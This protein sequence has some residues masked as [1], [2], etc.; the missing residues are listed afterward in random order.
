MVNR[1]FHTITASQNDNVSNTGGG[2]G[3]VGSMVIMY[4]F[5]EN[6]GSM[7]KT[8]KKLNLKTKIQIGQR[9]YSRTCFKPQLSSLGVWCWG[10]LLKVLDQKISRHAC[11]LI[12]FNCYYHFC[13]SVTWCMILVVKHY[14]RTLNTQHRTPKLESWVLKQVLEYPL[15]TPPLS[16]SFCGHWTCPHKFCI[17]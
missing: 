2:G 14:Y 15:S 13:S 8:N 4:G 10:L 1:I 12:K 16:P 7:V 3:T 5:R 11:G 9:W 6:K 17:F